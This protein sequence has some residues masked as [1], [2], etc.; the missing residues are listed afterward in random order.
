MFA[1][2]RGEAEATG[3]QL[4]QMPVQT[5]QIVLRLREFMRA[6]LREMLEVE[7]DKG[8]PNIEVYEGGRKIFGW[9]GERFVNELTQS[10]LE[11]I[12][13]LKQAPVGERV[14]G[15]SPLQVALNGAP[16]LAT[17]SQGGV[18]VNP[19][20]VPD[21]ATK[22]RPRSGASPEPNADKEQPERKSSLWADF[23][24]AGTALEAL[25]A[26]ATSPREESGVT[27]NAASR[28][29]KVEPAGVQGGIQR[30][31]E[32]LNA[33]S[34]ERVRQLL[35]AQMSEIVQLQ[36]Q[37]QQQE[38][39][40]SVLLRERLKEPDRPNWWQQATRAV[41]SV[42]QQHR[43]RSR[44]LALASQL[45][46]VFRTQTQPGQHR[47]E[48]ADYA[49]SR[50]GHSYTL[51]NRQGEVLMEFREVPLGVRVERMKD[52]WEREEIARSLRQ[53]TEQQQ[54]GQAIAGAFEPV[55][56]SEAE[57]LARTTRLVRALSDYAA[58]Q[59]GEV[60]VDGQLAYRWRAKADGTV[61]IEAKDGRGT[62]LDRA[63]GQLLSR[64]EARDLAHFERV[65]PRLERSQREYGDGVTR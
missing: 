40:I 1:V 28:F 8:E 31:R 63:N 5:A 32:S 35:V 21:G 29:E 50:R 45:R 33:L 14:E 44:D 20:E 15:V 30:V 59:G 62:L 57:T 55:G 2:G 22:Q 26:F 10:K 58:A 39:R 54:S 37:M 46:D 64:L 7:R 51:E 11:R 17:N 52:D 13:A 41:G 61:H 43:Q 38:R 34:E 47:Y 6:A 16:V 48:S 49:L 53:A 24:G 23:D 3:Q 4:N 36:Q 65:L 42:W 25:E 27:P 56:A 60:E 18:E 19:F 12:H 9:D